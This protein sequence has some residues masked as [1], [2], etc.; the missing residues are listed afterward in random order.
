MLVYGI[1]AVDALLRRNPHTVDQLLLQDGRDDKRLKA[2]LALAQNQGVS[3]ERVSREELA[4]L[5]E[6]RHQ[7]A[8]ARVAASDA[9]VEGGLQWREPELLRHVEGKAGPV[10]LLVLDGVTD[11]H[12]LGACLRSADA[13]G[14]DAVIV[15]RDNSASMTPVVRKVASG[16]AE[17]L[18]LVTVTNLSRTLEA[19]KGSGVWLFGAA[20]EAKK[21]IYNSD[22]TGS[23]ALIMG[24][25]GR[26]MRRLTREHCDHLIS[27]PMTG[28]VDSL[29][30]SVAAGVCLFEAR[31]QRLAAS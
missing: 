3:V 21:S 13:A 20:G 25:E 15:P 5:V 22:L 30:V 26:G 17:A 31:R 12:N 8:V 11:P 9:E 28:S 23:V 18:P 6:G 27:L 29:N 2:L 16:A 14:A 4:R 10:L 1:H 7:G 19:L 24:A